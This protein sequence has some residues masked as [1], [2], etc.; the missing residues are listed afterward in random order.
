[1]ERRTVL[2]AAGGVLAGAAL[3]PRPA[4]AV[5]AP[6]VDLMLV[7][8]ADVSRSI[9]DEK[10][11]LQRKG[12]AAAM[13]DPEVL[14]AI[15]AGPR[16]RIAVA[17]AEWSGS[18]SQKLVVPWAAVGGE[19]EARIFGAAV[20]R[21]PRSF[22][23]RTAIGSAIAFS[24]GLFT[25]APFASGRRVIDVSGDGDS[26]GGRDIRDARDDAL[27]QG[28]TT[29]NGIVILSDTTGPAYLVAH[30]HPPGGLQTYYRQ[31][32]AGGVNS[33]VAVAEDFDSFG[34]ALVAKL[35]QEI[36]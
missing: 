2:R 26:N 32:V 22:A 23:D 6:A 11:D 15:A 9:T 24:A 21:A 17:F 10:Y 35:V 12:Y 30:T 8:A 4:R 34:R 16:R 36:T 31:N 20:A 13:S 33:F 1:M 29:I 14:R 25:E 27:A 28:V 7:L 18:G 5:E 3:R 19:D